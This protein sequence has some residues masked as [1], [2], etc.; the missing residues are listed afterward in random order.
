MKILG[1]IPA[2][3]GSQGVPGKN[4][5]TIAGKPLLQ[6]TFESA[7][8][9]GVLDRL[10]LS[11][12]DPDAI[13]LA[14]DLGLEVPF[15]RPEA[16]ARHDSSMLDVLQHALS[17]LAQDGYVPDAL[18]LLQ[19]TSP[20]RTAETIRQAVHGLGDADAICSVTALPLT[21]CPHYVMKITED[22]NLDFFLPEGANF[23]RRQDVPAAYTRNGVVYLT[24]TGVILGK[25]SPDGLGSIYGKRCRPLVLSGEETIS[26]DTLADWQRAAAAL[27]QKTDSAP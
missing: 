9:A 8:A 1:L 17:T 2:R 16:L 24:R 19:P 7:T 22:G 15:Q 10:I 4:T 23:T 14:K 21:H 20:L 12:D 26:I 27:K 11:S 18:M 25:Q 13:T 6:W 5:K 3:G